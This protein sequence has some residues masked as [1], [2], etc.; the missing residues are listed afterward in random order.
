V[1]L[2]LLIVAGSV[3]VGAGQ[4]PA[5][6]PAAPA[7]PTAAPAQPPPVGSAP[8]GRAT[9]PPAPSPA[10]IE[11]ANLILAATRQALGGEKLA[12]IRTLT[13]S[14]RTR[15]V[16]GNNLVPIEFE[17]SLELPNKYLRRD[18]SPF[19]EADPTSVGFNGDE[20]IQAPAPAM[21]QLAARPA[22]RPG[23]P[24]PAAP[25]PEQLA[26][27]RRSRVMTIKQDFVRMALGMFA[28]SFATYPLTFAWAAVAEAPQ[29]KADALDVR[30]ANNFLMR[31]FINSQTR[32]P[33]MVSWTLPP[34]NVIVTVPGQPAPPTVAPGAVVVTGPAAPLATA[35]Q[36]EKDAYAKEVLAIRQKAQATPVEHR[37]YYAD[38]RDV[39]G[40]QLP[41][42]F[43]RA[44]GPDTTEET[45]VDRYRINQKIA[46][47]RFAPVR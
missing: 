11:R 32:Q 27:Q 24:A 35:T 44:I 41:F 15:R 5:R 14:G 39:D 26:A 22:A 3:A 10:A 19:E 13:M 9:A 31:F 8:G 12:A 30:G 45:T 34:T 36:A 18:E 1:C 29:G 43:R 37:V 20:L 16:R 42:R 4:A 47:E 7:V 46:P 25:T 2:A 6:E 21:P 38:Y 40:V 23:G 17:I 28:D 33:I